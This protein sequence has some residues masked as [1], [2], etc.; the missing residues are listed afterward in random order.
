[1]G[2]D[3]YIISLH[4]ILEELINIL[5]ISNFKKPARIYFLVI[6]NFSSSLLFPVSSYFSKYR[7]FF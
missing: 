1:M 5:Y 6:N 2:V 7:L 3:Q 4:G